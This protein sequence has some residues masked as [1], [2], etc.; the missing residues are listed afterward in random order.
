MKLGFDKP[1]YL[2]PFDHRRSFVADMFGFELP[3]SAQQRD[4]VTDSK[5]LI[6]EGFRQALAEGVSSE[7]AGILV[8][9]EL[10][11]DILRDAHARGYATALSV[12]Q[13]GGRDTVGCIVLGRGADEAKVRSWLAVAAAVPGFI[14][15]AVGRTTFW[16]AVS[17]CR[18]QTLSPAEAAT[19]IARRLREWVDI[20][21][22]GRVSRQ[23]GAA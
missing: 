23:A 12:E 11:A 13:S 20:F 8:D 22:A 4:Q 17:S 9:E 3:L 2:L 6:Y 10:G 15:F 5:Q 16:D 19:Q 7:S 14:G 21:E 18:A 1:L